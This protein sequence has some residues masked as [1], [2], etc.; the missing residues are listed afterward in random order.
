[1][2][3][4][5]KT[6]FTIVE[7]LVVITIIGLL[8]ALLLPAV[9]RARANARR[10][11][12]VNNLKQLGTAAVSFAAAKGYYPGYI[13][14]MP[15]R[16]DLNGDGVPSD[17]LLVSWMVQLLPEVDRND[18]YDSLQDGTFQFANSYVEL[19]ACPMDQPDTKGSPHL[20]YVVNSGTWDSDSVARVLTNNQ[21][22]RDNKAN[23]ISHN[24]AG[25]LGRYVGRPGNKKV[26]GQMKQAATAVRVAPDYISQNDGA[27]KT[28]LF[29]ENVDATTWI[30]SNLL[31]FEHAADQ[32]GVSFAWLR[33]FD[34]QA[35]INEQA[36]LASS[37]IPAQFARPSSNHNGLVVVT[38][39]DGHAESLNA[40]I[41]PDVLGRLMS[42]NG[43]EAHD[44]QGA[45][46]WQRVALSDA[47][48]QQ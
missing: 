24:L 46:P 47:D 13:N 22:W 40:E 30:G 27:A 43:D 41:S 38:F 37:P 6:G 26:L 16:G 15:T 1:M 28:L 32:G 14:E 36:G 5:R 25:L 48:I 34:Q 45:V 10:I 20:S 12:C 3:A 42:P 11:Q 4:K 19:A 35:K 39:A 44:A 31:G 9:G 8:M 17:T 21:G 33:S 18:I 7:L 29:S 2:R 23:G